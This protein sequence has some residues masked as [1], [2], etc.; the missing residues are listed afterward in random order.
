MRALVARLDPEHRLAG[1]AALLLALSLFLPWWRDPNPVF[2]ATYVGVRR[3]T[4]L[5]V[6]IFL[7]AAAVLALLARRAEG[8]VFHLP[9]SDGTLLAAAGGWAAFLVLFRMLDPPTRT[10]AGTSSDYG[11]RWGAFVALAAAVTLAAAGVRERR[12]HHRGEPESVAA[13]ADATPTVPLPRER[14]SA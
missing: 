7:V 6:S 10:I 9:L 14:T 1:I 5:E 13:D 4:F 11:L 3:L 8:R 2:G 12:R